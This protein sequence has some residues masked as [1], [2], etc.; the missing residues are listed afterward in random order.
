VPENRL[1]ASLPLARAWVALERQELSKAQHFLRRASRLKIREDELLSAVSALLH[2]RLMRDRGDR[3]GARE[4][5]EKVSPAGWLRSYI[6]GEAAA[7][8]SVVP[9]RA[10]LDHERQP[11]TAGS[12]GGPDAATVAQRIQQLLK[13]A[14]FEC[15]AGDVGA[16]RSEVAKALSLGAP[17]RIRRPFTHLPAEIR[18]MIRTDPELMSRAGWLRP[19]LV[20]AAIRPI[21]PTQVAA[22]EEQLSVRELE[23]L[24]LLSGL[25]TTEEIAAQLFISVNTVRTHVRRIFEK[26]CVSRRNDAV[27]RARELN[28]V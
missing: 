1:P 28:L 26:L 15:A 25:F 4:I 18:S 21:R 19:E 20:G 10:L 16:G 3:V 6:E 8:G 13:H 12:R 11:E 27:R 23:V 17:E 5:L 2:A 9:R 14:E 24:R 22:R 7:L